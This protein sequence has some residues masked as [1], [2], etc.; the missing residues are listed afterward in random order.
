MKRSIAKTTDAMI[1]MGMGM[2]MCSMCN[3][4]RS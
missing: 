2:C 3:F 4:C 1:M